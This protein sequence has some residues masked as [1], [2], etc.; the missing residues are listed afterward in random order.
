VPQSS[1]SLRR[2]LS[3]LFDD[4]APQTRT[5]QI[6]NALLATLI[7]VNVAAVI[8]ESVEPIR[9]QHAAIFTAIETGATAIF[10]VE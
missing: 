4:E 8:L 5:T 10:A 1:T 7:I 2:R 3:S 6:F 9:V